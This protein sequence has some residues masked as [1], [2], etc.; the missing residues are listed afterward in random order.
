MFYIIWP[1]ICTVVLL[2]LHRFAF[3]APRFQHHQRSGTLHP[4]FDSF[5]PFAPWFPIHYLQQSRQALGRKRSACWI[6]CLRFPVCF[7]LALAQADG[8]DEYGERISLPLNLN[9]K[10][11][12][13]QGMHQTAHF[14][15]GEF[16][17]TFLGRGTVDGVDHHFTRLQE[18]HNVHPAVQYFGA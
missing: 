18:A 6:G 2:I 3:H 17:Q 11:I 5:I 10:P 14:L 7:P 9:Q 16:L 12:D 15:H 13:N 4:D 8:E 1:I